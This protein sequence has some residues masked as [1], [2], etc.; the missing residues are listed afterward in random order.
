MSVK[1]NRARGRGR[2]AFVLGLGAAAVLVGVSAIRT[3]ALADYTDGIV[4]ADKISLEAA[5]RIWRKAA[6]QE[7]DYLS[8]IKLGD[9]YGDET[10]DNKYYDP[11]ESCM[12]GITWPSKATAP[13]PMSTIRARSASPGMIFTAPRKD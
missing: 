13:T 11:I 10:G 9:I 6:W 7:D 12:S 4:A 2:W 5:L 8:E 3:P 1:E